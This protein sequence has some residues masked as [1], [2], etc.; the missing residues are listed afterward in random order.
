MSSFSS[1]RFLHQLARLYSIQ[2]AYYDVNHHRQQA[3]DES[4]LAALRSLG[5][6]LVNLQ[7]VPSAWRER[8]QVVW[9]KVIE[10]VIV[11]WNGEAV[12][13]EVRLPRSAADANLNCHLDLETGEEMKWEWRGANLSVVGTAEIEGTQ[14]VVKQLRLPESLPWGIIG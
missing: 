13:V 11:A 9:Q 12:P 2:T 6:P 5:A 7:D 1:V 8:Q 3:S 14:Y 10:P 4:L